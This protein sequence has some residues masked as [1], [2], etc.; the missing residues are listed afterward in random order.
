VGSGSG[1]VADHNLL[2]SQPGFMNSSAGDFRLTSSS[3]AVDAGVTVPGVL[4]DWDGTARPQ[5]SGFDLGAFER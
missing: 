2:T 3:P 1:L 5:G 4:T